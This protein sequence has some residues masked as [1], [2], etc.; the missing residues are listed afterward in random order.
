MTLYFIQIQNWG[1]NLAEMGFNQEKEKLRV[2]EKA[3][4]L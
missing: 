4:G 2:S 1:D 3:Q